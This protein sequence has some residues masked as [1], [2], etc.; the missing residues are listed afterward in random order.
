MT[1][2]GWLFEDSSE[3]QCLVSTVA[4]RDAS[5]AVARAT[6]VEDRPCYVERVSDAGDCWVVESSR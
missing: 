1:V 2:L 6:A 4:V 5:V 3:P